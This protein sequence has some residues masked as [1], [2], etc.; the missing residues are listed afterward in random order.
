M[1]WN[2]VDQLRNIDNPP[3]CLFRLCQDLENEIINKR[4]L[5]KVHKKPLQQTTVIL[6]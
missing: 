2:L 4:Y 5:K 3:Q 6:M 1:A